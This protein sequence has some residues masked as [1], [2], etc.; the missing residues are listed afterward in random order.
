MF[1]FLRVPVNSMPEIS[2][3]VNIVLL[4]KNFES[5]NVAELSNIGFLFPSPKGD[6]FFRSQ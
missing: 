5:I 2:F 1:E 6:I 3:N 4:K